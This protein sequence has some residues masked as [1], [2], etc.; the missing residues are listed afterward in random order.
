MKETVDENKNN[1]GLVLAA[2]YG[3]NLKN[4]GKLKTDGKTLMI[5][6]L[7]VIF[8]HEFSHSKK[9]NNSF[10]GGDAPSM[11]FESSPGV[12][13]SCVYVSICHL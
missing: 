10:T 2:L 6:E 13:K 8:S 11:S 3:G 4:V 7:E 12:I 9:L 5:Q 1:W